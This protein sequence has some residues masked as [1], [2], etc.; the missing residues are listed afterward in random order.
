MTTDD[1]LRSELEDFVGRWVSVGPVEAR[2]ISAVKE[3]LA[4]HPEPPRDELNG[5]VTEAIFRAE[6]LTQQA[7]RA[8]TDVADL[9]KKLAVLDDIPVENIERQTAARGVWTARLRARMLEALCRK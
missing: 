5:A 3:L 4:K 6:R 9:E 7:A 1:T 2:V 8:W